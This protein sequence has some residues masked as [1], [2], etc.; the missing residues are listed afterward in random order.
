MLSSATLSLTGGVDSAPTT[1]V[2]DTDYY[3]L[4]LQ[5]AEVIANS[6]YRSINKIDFELRDDAVV[7]LGYLPSFFLKQIAQTMASQVIKARLSLINEVHV[8]EAAADHSAP[9]PD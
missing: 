1:R 3:Q 2:F 4:K 8:S 6:S 7:L 5:L 9:K